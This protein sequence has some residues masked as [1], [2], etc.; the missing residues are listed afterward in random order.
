MVVGWNAVLILPLCGLFV[1]VIGPSLVLLQFLTHRRRPLLKFS[2]VKVAFFRSVLHDAGLREDLPS[3]R[4]LE[5]LPWCPPLVRW[6]VCL[7]AR[8]Q[9][10][11]G[12]QFI[13]YPAPK[14]P[15]FAQ[16]LSLRTQVIDAAVASTDA[17]QLVT[18]GAGWDT[19]SFTTGAQ[20]FARLF[21]VDLAP[22]LEA[23]L[24]A[25]RAA[26]VDMSRVTFVSVDLARESW[27]DR[28]R[29]AGFDPTQR[30]LFIAE[31]L[32]YYL[33]PRDVD[34]LLA[35]VRTCSRGSAIVMDHFTDGVISGRQLPGVA[36]YLRRVMHEPLLSAI[37]HE[38]WAE[39]DVARWASSKGL[40]LQQW[41]PGGRDGR[42]F[43]GVVLARVP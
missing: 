1:L 4:M 26:G 3:R 13:T 33:T 22:M 30:S 5:E 2:A 17:T 10:W 6:G 42:R 35:Q 14:N 24:E 39:E 29:E 23:K 27:L 34:Q 37:G 19:R 31:G 21:E 8:I 16:L 9:R 7:G 20:R 18:L 43:G 28:L 25:L 11:T 15:S 32:V 36:A 38:T 12:I 40:A 41:Y